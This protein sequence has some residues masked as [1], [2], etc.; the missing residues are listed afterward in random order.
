M[1][2]EVV[3][4]DDLGDETGVPVAAVA[5]GVPR[6]GDAAGKREMDPSGVVRPVDD[7]QTGARA[8]SHRRRAILR[9]GPRD[10]AAPIY[11]A[12]M[13]DDL[14][15]GFLAGPLVAPAEA[16]P[17]AHARRL[18]R[19][20]AAGRPI[21]CPASVADAG[22]VSAR[23]GVL[24]LNHPGVAALWRARTV[25]LREPWRQVTLLNA[26]GPSVLRREGCEPFPAAYGWRV[27]LEDDADAVLLLD[28]PYG[29][30]FAQVLLPPN[31]R[32]TRV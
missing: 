27:R 4:I 29:M 24:R 12:D 26:L 3:S 19:H 7:V 32:R 25:G 8:G 23:T 10:P 1:V 15:A 30:R 21:E 22:Q 13:L 6:F 28:G 16:N 20:Y 14:L 11:P 31:G 18:A 2:G 9:D 5:A 17:A